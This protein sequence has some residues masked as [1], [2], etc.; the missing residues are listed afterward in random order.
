M[1]TCW[2]LFGGSH[3][4]LAAAP[5]RDRAVNRIGRHAFLWGYL[6][7]ASLLFSALVIAYANVGSLGPR[8]IDLGSVAWGRPIAIG[9]IS[10]GVVLMTAGFAPAGYWESPSA[11]LMEGV[12]SP[13]GLERITRHP[14][15]AGVVLIMGAHALLARSLAGTVFFA[16]FVALAVFG[17]VHQARKLRAR[18]GEPFERY[19]ATTSAIPF[20]AIV[21]GDQRLVL[22]ELPWLWIALGV[23]AVLALHRFHAGIMAYDGAPLI[24]G[25][26]GGTVAIGA[27]AMRGEARRAG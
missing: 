7:V 12:R 4:V 15:F 11:V 8:G 24:A 13:R 2:L 16:G 25:V 10:I 5:I 17:P 14:I 20:L 9:V 21:R 1:A 26:V 19:L 18:H 22:R 27:I 6:V 23:A 3:V